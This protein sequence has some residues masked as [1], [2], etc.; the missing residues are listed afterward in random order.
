MAEQKALPPFSG[1]ATCPKCGGRMSSLYLGTVQACKQFAPDYKEY[2]YLVIQLEF[3]PFKP[4]GR[5]CAVCRHW[6][7]EAP[8]D[9]RPVGWVSMSTG[10]PDFAVE[11]RLIGSRWFAFITCPGPFCSADA[12]VTS[13]AEHGEYEGVCGDNHEIRLTVVPR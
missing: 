2:S 10:T 8:L 5:R 3:L 9:A 7:L 6:W 12:T 13:E 4:I 1:P 11:C